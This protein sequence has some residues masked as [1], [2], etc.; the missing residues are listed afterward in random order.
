[1]TYNKGM[2]ETGASGKILGEA[3]VEVKYQ[4]LHGHYADGEAWELIKPDYRITDLSYGSMR[5]DVMLSPRVAQQQAGLGLLETIAEADIRL[6]QKIITMMAYPVG[7]TG[8]GMSKLTKPCWADLDTRL[9]N[10]VCYNKQQQHF[11]AILVLPIA[12][13]QK[14]TVCPPSTVNVRPAGLMPKPG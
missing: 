1:M 6:I 4:S 8:F 13:S 7:Q 5:E 12:Y 2:A 3:R 10:P 14:K 11:E 9:T